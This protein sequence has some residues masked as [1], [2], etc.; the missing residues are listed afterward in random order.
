MAVVPRKQNERT[1]FSG[2]TRARKLPERSDNL[3]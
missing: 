1:A 2:R 3:S